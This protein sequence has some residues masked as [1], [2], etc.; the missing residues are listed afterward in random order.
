MAQTQ[1]QLWLQVYYNYIEKERMGHFKAMAKIC[2]GLQ[3]EG[4]NEDEIG[5]ICEYIE[6]IA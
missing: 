5:K 6:E 4:A 2:E 3:K 1:E